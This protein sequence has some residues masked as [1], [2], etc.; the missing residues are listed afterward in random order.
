MDGGLMSKET[1]PPFEDPFGIDDI[2]CVELEVQI[3]M[4]EIEAGFAR[5]AV[6]DES[7]RLIRGLTKERDD[8]RK[9]R[10]SGSKNK[11]LINGVRR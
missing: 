2:D 11:S 3:V 10:Q 1:F 7:K 6:D 4:G 8:W 9:W 5:K